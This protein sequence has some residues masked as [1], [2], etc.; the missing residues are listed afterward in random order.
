MRYMKKLILAA[1]LIAIV[2]IG[3]TKEQKITRSSVLI[4]QAKRNISQKLKNPSTAIFIDSTAQVVKLK[5][6]DK[7]SWKVNYTVY[8]ENSLGGVKKERYTVIYTFSGGDSLDV[9]NYELKDLF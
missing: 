6:G 9:K 1:C 5:G 4:E 2:T 3:C 7:E 8:G